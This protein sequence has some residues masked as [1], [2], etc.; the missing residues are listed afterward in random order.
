MIK[1]LTKAG[2][3]ATI[4]FASAALANHST[5]PM[6]ATAGSDNIPMAGDTSTIHRRHDGIKLHI[7]TSGLDPASP[8]TVWAVVF[9][10]PQY[11]QAIPCGAADL[12]LSPTHDARVEASLILAGGGLSAGDGSGTFVGR[13]PHSWR[14]AA[15]REVGYGP[16]LLSRRA[17]V[18]AVLRGHG[19]P[20][21]PDQVAAIT[22][23]AGG[24]NAD[25]SANPPC[26]NQQV[27]IHLGY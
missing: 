24:C 12:P 7:R 1:T 3:L 4:G 17:E 26:E 23:L 27:A 21:A 14:A 10:R 2:A 22:S 11:C 13:V 9:N 8:Y 18:H 6:S 25:N 5:V 20:A 16:G 15:S 19:Y